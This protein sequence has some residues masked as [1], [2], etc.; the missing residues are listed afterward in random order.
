[1]GLPPSY[2]LSR[3]AAASEK[4]YYAG[5]YEKNKPDGRRDADFGSSFIIYLREEK[6]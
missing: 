2:G 4:K 3:P 5:D 1:M 6:K